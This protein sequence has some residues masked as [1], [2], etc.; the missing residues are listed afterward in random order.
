MRFGFDTVLCIIAV[1]TNAIAA[2][3]YYI[4]FDGDQKITSGYPPKRNDRWDW[5]QEKNLGFYINFSRF[6]LGLICIVFGII[7]ILLI[8]IPE[9]MSFLD[10]TLLRGIVY[11][12][13]GLAVLGCANDLG[14]AA[15]ALQ[16]IIGAVMIVYGIV[17]LAMH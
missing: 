1:C 17:K 8:F 13:S 6:S 12:F 9:K 5:V 2:S 15:G 4:N 14:I 16:M 10:S 11:A 3:A 7:E